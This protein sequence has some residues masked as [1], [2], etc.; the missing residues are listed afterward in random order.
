ML[1]SKA[2]RESFGYW[3]RIDRT[4]DGKR[5]SVFQPEEDQVQ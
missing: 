4:F 2:D 5:I 3:Y 1:P